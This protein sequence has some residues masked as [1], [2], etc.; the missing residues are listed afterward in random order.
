MT[1]KNTNE[2]KNDQLTNQDARENVNPKNVRESKEDNM[3]KAIDMNEALFELQKRLETENHENRN[4]ND[5]WVLARLGDIVNRYEIIKQLTPV[6]KLTA[7][8][9]MIL[10]ESICGSDL[11]SRAISNL[12]ETLMDCS[13]G[14]EKERLGL[15]SKIMKLSAAER[16]ALI[17][18]LDL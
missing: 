5:E 10:G 6:A 17:E 13:T 4:Q 12:H 11:T 8:E 18:S 14:D 3:E 15:R 7:D 1:M 16:I 9:L 2:T